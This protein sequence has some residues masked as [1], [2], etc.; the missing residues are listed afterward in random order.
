[1]KEIEEKID[2]R[3]ETLHKLHVHVL[4]MYFY[5]DLHVTDLEFA[6]CFSTRIIASKL[7]YGT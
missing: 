7:T 1:M 2:R 5:R 6:V 4:Y 3:H